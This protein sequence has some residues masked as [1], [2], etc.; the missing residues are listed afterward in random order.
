MLQKVTMMIYR[1]DFLKNPLP[2][3]Y[4]FLSHK[5]NFLRGGKN[6]RASSDMCYIADYERLK[7]LMM[8]EKVSEYVRTR[9]KVVLVSDI[10]GHL[11]GVCP[12]VSN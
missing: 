9:P 1:F 7:L 12:N 8:S 10:F 3:L 11:K 5:G 6:S 2:P 4:F